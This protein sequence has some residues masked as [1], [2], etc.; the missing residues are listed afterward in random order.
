VHKNFLS[1]HYFYR[2]ALNAGRGLVARKVSVR[3][4]A[5]LLGRGLGQHNDVNLG[6]I[7]MRVVDFLLVL[8]ELF[9][10]SV[11]AETLRAKIDRKSA[12]SF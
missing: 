3:P 11:T 10:L 12:I 1:T 6:L 7:A 4:S 8:I 9:S 5:V 2:A